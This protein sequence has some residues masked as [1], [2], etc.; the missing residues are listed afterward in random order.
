MLSFSVGPNNGTSIAK[1][2]PT[3]STDTIMSNG[4]SNTVNTKHQC[5]T[6]MNEYE[7]KSLEELRMEDYLANRKWPQAATLD[8]FVFGATSQPSIFG[9]AAIEAT[10]NKNMFSSTS[11]AFG[12]IVAT[13]FGT[14]P[15]RSTWTTGFGATT[16]EQPKKNWALNGT[17]LFGATKRPSTSDAESTKDK[18]L[19]DST[20]SVFGQPATGFRITPTQSFG[21]TG[22]NDLAATTTDVSNSLGNKQPLFFGQTM[23][24]S[25]ASAF[26]PTTCLDVGSGT[27]A[28]QQQQNAL[29]ANT[30]FSGSVTHV[31]GASGTMRPTTTSFGVIPSYIVYLFV[32]LVLLSFLSFLLRLLSILSF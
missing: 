10:E 24:T 5:I 17:G 31:G 15:I 26:G 32:F 20:I 28:E 4:R 12:Q 18:G 16:V 3:I 6:A 2:Q 25:T 22:T 29:T 14:Q 27:I 1:Y 11:N 13:G 30:K 19:V 23:D 9:Q 8:S 21:P 7:G